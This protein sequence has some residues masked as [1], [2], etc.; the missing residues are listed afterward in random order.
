MKR[1]F[2][3]ANDD[4][5]MQIFKYYKCNNPKPSYEDV[6]SLQNNKTINK[7]M[8]ISFQLVIKYFIA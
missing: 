8:L 1:T 6:I 7:V 5:F 4:V 3:Q 2:D